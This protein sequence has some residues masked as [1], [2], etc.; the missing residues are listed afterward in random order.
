MN[1]HNAPDPSIE[2]LW[3]ICGM[4]TEAGRIMYKFYGSHYKPEVNYPKVKTK[5]PEQL[6]EEKKKKEVAK[7]AC[8][9]KTKIDY[10]EPEPKNVG[11]A[12]APIDFIPKKKNKAVIEQELNQAKKAP[13][14]RPKPGQNRAALI[15][16]L[17]EKYQFS[18]G[19]LPKAAQTTPI[20]FAGVHDH[21]KPGQTKMGK[22]KAT[23]IES[24]ENK[25][26]MDE[27]DELF[28]QISLEI[29][30]RQQHLEAIL[31]CEK[32]EAI[33]KRIKAEITSRISELQRI[34]E[35]KQKAKK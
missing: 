16:E 27:L 30:E 32:N 13:L 2:N 6:A 25:T 35:L 24:K 31:K 33:E 10:P 23:P 22:S 12:P 19:I 11:R 14:V 34:A 4:N 8:P 15:D 28:E 29:E 20:S 7:K 9:Q 26:D 1:I 17:Q 18:A 3:K 21:L 5:T